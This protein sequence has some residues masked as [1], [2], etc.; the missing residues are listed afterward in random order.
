MNVGYVLKQYVHHRILKD[1]EIVELLIGKGG[2]VA[3]CRVAIAYSETITNT[4]R[5]RTPAILRDFT[6]SRMVID[7]KKTSENIR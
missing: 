6:T 2:F 1:K 4:G 3:W 5:R 7:M